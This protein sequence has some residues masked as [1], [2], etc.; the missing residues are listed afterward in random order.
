VLWH[1]STLE[2][3]VDRVQAGAEGIS[4]DSA[5]MHVIALIRCSNVTC[6]FTQGLGVSNY[7]VTSELIHLLLYNTNLY[8]PCHWI[9]LAELQSCGY[10]AGILNIEITPTNLPCSAA[11]LRATRRQFKHRPFL[12]AILPLDL[13]CRAT[14]LR[15]TR[16]E[17]EHRIRSTS[18][19]L[20]FA[21]LQR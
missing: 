4:F 10:L 17:L 11:K 15:I 8:R 21:G 7:K 5:N 18:I 1:I 19:P 6:Y 20:E 9:Y 16:S 14:K 13:L 3:D 12:L 2:A